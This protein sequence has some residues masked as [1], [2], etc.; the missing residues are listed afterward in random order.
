M[1]AATAARKRRKIVIPIAPASRIV[2]A[3][4]GLFSWR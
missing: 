4:P 3:L 2:G 1:N